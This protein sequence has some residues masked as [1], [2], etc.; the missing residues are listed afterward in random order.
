MLKMM[1]AI[2]QDKRY[3][4]VVIYM[5]LRMKEKITNTK[6][7]S[8]FIAEELRRKIRRG[9]IQPGMAVMSAPEIAKKYFDLRF[10]DF[11]V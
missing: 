9:R 2:K 8:R 11:S 3:N 4:Y 5:E 10:E 7:K 6:H 1:F